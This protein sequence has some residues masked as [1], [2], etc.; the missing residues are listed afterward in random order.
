[1]AVTGDFVIQDPFGIQ[2]AVLEL[3]PGQN[4]TVEVSAKC[5]RKFFDFTR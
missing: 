5:Y 3:A 1:M 2:P 4:A